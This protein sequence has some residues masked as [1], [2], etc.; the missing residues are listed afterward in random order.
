MYYEMFDELCKFKDVRPGT[1]ARETGISTATI[2]AWKQ[3]K[4]TPKA[5]K[6]T[7]IAEY[8]G[9]TLDE[10]IYA[11]TAYPNARFIHDEKTGNTL[12]LSPQDFLA[13][14]I[15][16]KYYSEHGFYEHQETAKMAQEMKDNSELRLLFDAAKDASPEDLK[17]VRDMLLLLK[18]R[19]NAD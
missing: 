19:R 4:Y 6:L 1:V 12:E 15:A 11:C 8:F 16:E 5:D 2:T 13:D 7:K 10:F 18:E 3:G 17:T 9:L 14:L